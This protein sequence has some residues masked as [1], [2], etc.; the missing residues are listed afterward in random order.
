MTD[1]ESKIDLKTRLAGIGI[2][3]GGG[4]G[5][6]VLTAGLLNPATLAATGGWSAVGYG[7]ANFGQGAYTNYLVQKHLYGEE[8]IKW[9]EVWASGGMSMIP[10]TQIGA[11]AK[12]AKYVGA[13]G[14]VKRGLVSGAGVGLAGE[15]LRVG[16]DEGRWLEPYEA[17]AAIGIGGGIGGGLTHVSKK[18]DELKN[19][20]KVYASEG[21]KKKLKKKLN[22]E[23][24]KDTKPKRRGY[25]NRKVTLDREDVEY[26]PTKSEILDAMKQMGLPPDPEKA[27]FISKVFKKDVKDIQATK[28]FLN[29][30]FYR[31]TP[32]NLE[33]L[34][35][36]ISAQEGVEYT[37]ADLSNIIKNTEATT[38]RLVKGMPTSHMRIRNLV[39]LQRILKD[40]LRKLKQQPTF[41]KGHA[42]SINNILKKFET[43]AD[44]PDN[45]FIEEARSIYSRDAEGKVKLER[46][47]N[48]SKKDISDD[49][50][51]V[52]RLKGFS[53]TVGE[54]ILKLLRK[55]DLQLRNLYNKLGVD[56]SDLDITPPIST[57]E[58]VRDG[59]KEWTE[60]TVDDLV[61]SGVDPEKAVDWLLD[62]NVTIG[63]A[64]S[65]I[66]I[67]E[68]MFLLF[69]REPGL[70]AEFLNALIGKKK[71]GP[72]KL[73][74]I[75]ISDFER[76]MLAALKKYFKENPSYLAKFNDIVRISKKAKKGIKPLSAEDREK[77]RSRKRK[78]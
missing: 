54:S 10:F 8:N 13:A 44:R 6:D 52:Q 70:A 34:A 25:V 62:I 28:K 27:A 39:D 77:F 3:V 29:D 42:N 14:S 48:I 2:E 35:E 4:V 21:D 7:L 23:T 59:L 18:I 57:S 43:G 67:E 60:E 51:V 63:D 5:T 31:N 36:A 74:N 12:A 56:T 19:P 41:N 24:K 49:P 22:K 50:L 53:P 68:D 76:D 26:V 47:G 32:K 17:V 30:Y 61:K 65:A 16:I 71:R 20:L 55:N 45:I 78:K 58:L 72:G 11:S 66:G 73:A 75:P 33:G 1:E 46:I 38:T 64:M 15:Q 69:K 9:G 40:R 37:V